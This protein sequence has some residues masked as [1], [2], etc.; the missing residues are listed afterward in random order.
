M[1]ERKQK[2]ERMNRRARWMVGKRKMEEKMEGR[3]NGKK[4]E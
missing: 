3:I 4:I 2:K 1:Q